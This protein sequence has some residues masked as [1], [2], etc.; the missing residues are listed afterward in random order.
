MTV[1]N[2]SSVPHLIQRC[3]QLRAQQ[4][5][6]LIEILI[7]VAIIGVVLAAVTLSL[8]SKQD[9]KIEAIAEQLK[10][11][12]QLASQQAMLRPAQ[13]GFD[14]TI[15]RDQPQFYILDESTP[16]PTWRLIEGQVAFRTTRLPSEYKLEFGDDIKGDFLPLPNRPQI[17]FHSNGYITPFTLHFTGP[18]QKPL[19]TIMVDEGGNVTLDPS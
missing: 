11:Q 17:E 6:T 2:N 7:V 18:D 16:T 15:D 12:L 14:I 3:R 1:P 9:R 13:Y 8:V 10:S 5:F 19:Y 4:G